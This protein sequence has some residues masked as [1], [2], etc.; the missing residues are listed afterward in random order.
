MREPPLREGL[1]SRNLPRSTEGTLSISKHRRTDPR[2][3][4]RRRRRRTSGPPPPPRMGP[5]GVLRSTEDT[6]TPVNR[7]DPLHPRRGATI[8][9]HAEV[10]V[11]GSTRNGPLPNQGMPTPAIA[12]QGPTLGVRYG[13]NSGALR[14]SQTVGTALHAPD[15]AP[16]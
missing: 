14:H 11:R 7:H 5:L 10:R 4:V 3:G 1:M 13:H 12:R 15:V 2:S 6:Q 16:Q 9:A 8:P